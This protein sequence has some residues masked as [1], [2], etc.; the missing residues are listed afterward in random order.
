[1]AATPETTTAAP[2]VID[3]VRSKETLF[4]LDTF[5]DAFAWMQSDSANHYQGVFA[6]T[7]LILN[8]RKSDP[9]ILVPSRVLSCPCTQCWQSV[10]S[11]RPPRMCWDL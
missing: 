8:K 7:N 3:R 9:A 11:L 4:G 10:P 1:M 5:Q 6:I 2:D